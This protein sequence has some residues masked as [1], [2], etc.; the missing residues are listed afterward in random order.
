MATLVARP[1]D[2]QALK[3]AAAAAAAGVE[4]TVVAPANAGKI[5]P[6][7]SAPA[8]GS[9]DLLLVLPSGATLGEPNAMARHLAASLHSSADL[10]AECWLEWEEVVLRPA[11]YSGDADALR[12]ALQRLPAGGALLSGGPGLGVAD[13]AVFATLHAAALLQ[14][15][16]TPAAE[17]YMAAAGAQPAIA[18]GMEA[19]AQGKPADAA[20]AAAAADAAAF[21]AARPKLP[22]PGRRNLLI[23]SALPY[24]NNVPHL[25]NIIGCVLSADVYARFSRAR[26]HNCIYVCGTDEYGTATETKALEEGLTCQQICDKYHAVHAAIYQWFGISFDQFGRTPSRAQ[27]AIGQEMFMQLHAKGR[28]VEQT[29]EQLYSEP[30]QKFLA[31]R[32]VVGTCPKCRYEVRRGAT[33]VLNA[34]HVHGP[35]RP[36]AWLH[37]W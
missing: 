18:A 6:E 15:A 35:P 7:G 27:T 21:A 22:L 30:L 10:S 24:V 33:R 4:L 29:I 32:F 13:V 12:A 1:G 34:A 31:D 2:P 16:L 23:T 28:L 8:F 14:R 20:A 25:G 17:A 11:V 3:A 36:P 37:A 5:V 19:V 26:G 9:N